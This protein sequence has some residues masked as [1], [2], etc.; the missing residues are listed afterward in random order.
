MHMTIPVWVSL[1]FAGW[2]LLTLQF[3]CMSIMGV[4]V[5]FEAWHG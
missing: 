3:V 4:L 1:A 2:T 5:A